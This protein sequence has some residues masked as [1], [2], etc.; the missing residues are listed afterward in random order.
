MDQTRNCPGKPEDCEGALGRIF[1][2]LQGPLTIDN[3]ALMRKKL[4]DCAPCFDAYSYEMQVRAVV[5]SRCHEDAPIHLRV[6]IEEALRTLG[7][8]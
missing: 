7:E 2:A 3:A 1:D 4:H 8:S 5:A 6:R